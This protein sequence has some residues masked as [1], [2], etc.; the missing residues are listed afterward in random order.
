MPTVREPDG[1]AMCSR[2]T[3]LTAVRPRDGAVPVRRAA[4]RGRGRAP[5]ARRP[6]AGPRGP[7]SCASRSRSSTTSC[8]CTRTRWDVP[9]WYR[10]EALLAVAGR[11][12]TTRLIDNLPVLVGP[13]GGALDVFSDMSHTRVRGL[14]HGD[15][16]HAP[17]RCRVA[18]VPPHR[19]G[20]RPPMSSWSGSGIAGLTCALRL[21]RAGRPGAA[22]DQDRAVGGGS[23][24]WA[25][26]GIA[27][28]LDPEDTPQEH[29]VRHPRGRGRAVRP[30]GGAHP[31]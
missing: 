22:R 19:G 14:R 20:R 12:G 4:R 8:S 7:C 23:T 28:A 15:A 6:S 31:W 25:Q 2:N 21:R 18:S 16:G 17:S 24:Q 29:L 9:E 5:R 3:Y 10:G 11:V 27:A 30:G 13:G 1:L 26:G